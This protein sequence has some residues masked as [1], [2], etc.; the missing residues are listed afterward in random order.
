MKSSSLVPLVSF[1][2]LASCTPK[3]LPVSSESGQTIETASLDIAELDFTYLS[4]RSRVKYQDQAT[5]FTATANIRML[6]DS[7]IWFS[8]SSS[9]GI[10]AIRGIISQDSVLIMDRLKKTYFGYNFEKLGAEFNF[11]LDF[12]LVQ[13]MLL[14]KMSKPIAE[15]DLLRKDKGYLVLQ[16]NNGSMSVENFIDK[17]SFLLKR[18]EISQNPKPNKLSMEFANFKP[19]SEILFPH[20]NRIKVNYADDGNILNNIIEINYNRVL[21]EDEKLKFPFGIPSKYELK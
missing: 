7:L 18:V 4:T 8:L 11:P 13:A 15:N 6:K 5:S 3:S 9:I 21:F 16:Q 2:F 1:I 19:V 14:G 12:T 17:K 20:A 10:E